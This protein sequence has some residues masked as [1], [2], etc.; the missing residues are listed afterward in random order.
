MTPGS[1]ASDSD[2]DF[3][4]N[5]AASGARV[6]VQPN[7]QCALP[8]R[9]P[10]S[11]PAGNTWN[12]QLGW[13]VYFPDESESD[14]SCAGRATAVQTLKQF[15]LTEEGQRVLTAIP[16]NSFALPLN[17]QQLSHRSSAPVLRGIAA[18]IEQ[19]PG[20]SLASM[21]LAA[22][23]AVEELASKNV[24]S[25]LG[26]QE[27]SVSRENRLWP[28]IYN[29]TPQTP[30]KMLRGTSVGKFVT[31]KGTVVRVSNIRQ[32]LVSMYFECVR[33]GEKQF[34]SFTDY[35]Y[36]MPVKC[37]TEKCRSRVFTPLRDT[38]ETTDWQKIRI[39]ELQEKNDEVS[40]REEGRMPRTIDAEL[41]SDLI[42]GCIPGDVVTVCGIVRVLTIERN[43]YNRN[44]KCLYYM[45]VEANSTRTTRNRTSSAA[46]SSTP[47]G[48]HVEESETLAIHRVIR[49]VVREKDSFGF[50]VHS[51]VPSIYGHEMVKAGLLLSLFGGA[52]RERIGSSSGS[53]Q[54]SVRTDIHCLVVGD[55]GL[56]K[57]QMLKA[58]VNIAPRGVYVCGNTSSTAGLTVTVVR[59]AS[60]DF[61]LE[62]GALVL[63][64]RGLCCIDEFDKMGAEHGALL[65]AME[66]QSVSV[67]KAGLVCNLSAR[68]TVLAAANPVGGHYDRSRTVCENLKIA[69]PLLSRFD[70]VFILVDKADEARDRFISEHVMKMFGMRTTGRSIKQGWR[71]ADDDGELSTSQL[72]LSGTND[73]SENEEC[74]GTLLQRLRKLRVSDPL[75]PRL[76]RQY[77]TYAKTHVQPELSEGAKRELQEFYLELRKKAQAQTIDVTPITTRQLESL[78]RL[79]EARA[80][81]VMRTVVTVEDARDVIEIMRESMIETLTDETGTVDLGRASGMSRSKDAHRF[82]KALDVEAKR[83][84]CG[85]FSRRNLKSVAEGI[86]I[87]GERFERVIET[88]NYQGLLMKRGVGKWTLAGSEFADVGPAD[89]GHEGAGNRTQWTGG[90][91]GIR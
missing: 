29:F 12:S 18:A 86:G 58:M 89:E 30:V 11:L 69:L 40:F 35:K 38:A 2:D 71:Q 56:G 43:G 68:T 62:A 87:C 9:R 77:V 46:A 72:S 14:P 5:A 80:R 27:L 79:S 54:V 76:F 60:G 1:N 51:A 57:S 3:D 26:W 25:F 6:V 24:A 70:L 74:Q 23:R 37:P 33:C 36:S 81:A 73:I 7:N 32:Q 31:I 21:G 49:E 64:D 55:P 28:R 4:E 52:T 75:P 34:R 53:E 91:T 50:L 59:E 85:I 67:A 17:Y 47:I 20:D 63:G 66:Q 78:I 15:F 13:L 82:M 42:D 65:E 19:S 10:P 61:A 88:V 48:R 83:Q 44:T 90:T 16:C 39:Q 8:S 84:R 41:F 22:C 45:Y